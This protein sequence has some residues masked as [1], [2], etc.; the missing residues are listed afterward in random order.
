MGLGDASGGR[1]IR[2]WRLVS[3]IF[4][5]VQKIDGN[6]HESW[7]V[8]WV[9]WFMIPI[10]SIDIIVL[11]QGC[12]CGHESRVHEP[13]QDANSFVSRQVESSRLFFLD[14][15]GD[16]GF[17]VVFGGF[18]SCVADYR[19]DRTDFP[20]YCLEFVSRGAGT[21]CLAGA[22]EELRPG[23][24]FL[25][26]PGLPH[27]IKSS[28][29]SPLV[30]YFVG[31][32]G[33]G[34]QE[35]LERYEI[36]AGFISRCL[37]GEPIRRAFDTLIDRGVRKSGSARPLCALITQQLLLM[38]RDDATDLAKTDSL[39]FASY[40]RVKQFIEREY[41]QLRKL[42]EIAKACELDGPYLCRLFARFHD[43]SPYQFLTRLRMVHASRILLESAATVKEVAAML[44]FND[45]F[46]FSRVFKSVHH[47]P[48]SRFR[49]SMHP[50][51]TS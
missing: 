39:A 46:H 40:S 1:I 30:K 17:Q 10:K 16:E 50:Q 15:A 19:I 8:D 34:V 5:M 38:C 41:L 12:D 6:Y 20:W 14:A 43:E 36:S 42:E 35:F 2:I 51:W 22:S 7:V 32:T 23:S 11:I 45:A 48:P 37:K 47:A 21:L 33:G 18:E 28:A 27:Q 31:F 49:Q 3:L 24:F 4:S 25:Y 44:G 26:G 29:E 9:G 13:H